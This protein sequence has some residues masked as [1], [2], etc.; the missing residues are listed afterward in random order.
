MAV[1]LPSC[2]RNSWTEDG[3]SVHTPDLILQTSL[4]SSISL[5]QSLSLP[6]ILFLRLSV[7]LSVLTECRAFPPGYENLYSPHN[8]DS[9]SDKI[10]TKLYS[11]DTKNKLN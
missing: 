5:G 9:S 4:V 6:I 1:R 8:S 10:D 3:Q 11:K 2:K 7:S